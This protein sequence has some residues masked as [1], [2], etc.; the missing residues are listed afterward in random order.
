MVLLHPHHGI[1]QI[2]QYHGILI[3]VINKFLVMVPIINLFTV[4]VK[5]LIKYLMILMQECYLL[6]V[7]IK[8][9]LIII[10]K[11]FNSLKF[12]F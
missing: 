5:I 2:K 6:F 11:N 7:N 1:G 10:K 8:V 9:S 12:I 4:Q 3:Q